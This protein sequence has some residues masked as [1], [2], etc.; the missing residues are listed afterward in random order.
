MDPWYSRT[1][2]SV[3]VCMANVPAWPEASPP[4]PAHEG[5]REDLAGRGKAEPNPRPLTPP[6]L[7]MYPQR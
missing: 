7:R 5:S 6:P 3:A 2:V 4:Y 1:R